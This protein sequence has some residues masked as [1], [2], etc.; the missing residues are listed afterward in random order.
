MSLQSPIGDEKRTRTGIIFLVAGTL[1]V[2][3]AWGSWVFRTTGNP[4]A[5]G[6]VVNSGAPAEATGAGILAAGVGLA[7]FAGLAFVGYLLL[8][9]FRR[10]TARRDAQF[11]FPGG[12]S[13]QRFLK[14][15]RQDSG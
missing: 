3:W 1:L 15:P 2:V 11:A 4:E 12:S 7:A 10:R 9:R 5:H 6:E 13:D 8:R 14:N